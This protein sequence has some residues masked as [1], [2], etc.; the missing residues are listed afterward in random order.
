VY[1]LLKTEDAVS[2]GTTRGE[3]LVSLC[4]FVALYAV[5]AFVALRVLVRLAKAGPSG[6][7]GHDESVDP[8]LLLTY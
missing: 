1:G 7:H 6:G 3:V 8:N 4:G 2:P 5:L